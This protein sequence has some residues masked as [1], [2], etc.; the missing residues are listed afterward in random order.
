MVPMKLLPILSIVL[1]LSVLGATLGVIATTDHTKPSTFTTFGSEMELRAFLNDRTEGRWSAEGTTTDMVAE[2]TSSHSKTNV[3]VEGVDE[4]DTVKT[5]GTMLFIADGNKV[6]IIRAG[7]PLAKVT[8]IVTDS[9]EYAYVHSLYLS[10]DRLIV[11]YIVYETSATSGSSAAMDQA[12]YYYGTA[13]RTCVRVYDLTD[14]AN[15]ALERS[16]GMSGNCVTSRLID[17]TLYLVTEQS[18]WS[19]DNMVL[20]ER[21]EDGKDVGVAATEIGYDPAMTSVSSFV[22]LLAFD[23]ASGRTNSMSALTGS[24]SVVYMSPTALY[25]AMQVWG[26]NREI[27]A[28]GGS[29]VTTSIYRIEVHGTIMELAARGSVEGRPLNQFALDERGDR[30]RVATTTSRPALDNQVHMFD[31]SLKE[32]GSKTGIAPGESIYSCRFM[33]DRLYLVTFLQVDPLFVVDLSTDQPA[34]LGELKVPGTSNY[35]QMIDPGLMGIG[36]ENGSVKVSLFDVDDPEAM[37]EIGS[38]VVD[39]YSYSTAQYDHKAVLYIPSAG[40][41]VIPLTQYGVSTISGDAVAYYDYGPTSTALALH[42][43]GQGVKEVGRI[44]H[45]NATVERSLYIGEVLYTISDTTVI[46]SL[47]GNLKTVSSLTYGQERYYYGW[48]GAEPSVVE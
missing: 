19:G 37:T 34:V 32:V 9:S 8:D 13:H 3:Q 28:L 24:T 10:G 11:I 31:L 41:L 43:D 26:G 7:P 35:L 27:L 22:N 39:G 48:G 33:G 2:A 16:A 6:H 36:F 38:L 45:E 47:M 21:S 1:A 40:M 44:V 23:V 20:P 29:D 4:G 12:V 15:P 18:V 25:L 17:T 30:L 46:A 14:P 5:D 42:L